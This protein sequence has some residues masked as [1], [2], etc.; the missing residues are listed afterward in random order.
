MRGCLERWEPVEINDLSE[1]A[2]AEA[3]RT[4]SIF[5]SFSEQEG[6]GLP[7]AEAM[8]SGCYVVGY[9]GLAGR[10]Y[11][12]AAICTPVEEGNVLAFA[13][14][15]EQAMGRYEADPRAFRQIGLSAAARINAR[16]SRQALRED[17]T[18][19]YQSLPRSR[20]LLS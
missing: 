10:E 14:A 6:F 8:A 13:M 12:D 1:S 2:T 4:S 17:L 19:F 15:V 3:L 7:P 16:Y 5:L 9:T 18:S 11:F 20:Q